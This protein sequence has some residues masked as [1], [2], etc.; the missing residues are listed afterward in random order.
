[1]YIRKVVLYPIRHTAQNFP[2]RR[3]WILPEWFMFFSGGGD[4]GVVFLLQ[5]ILLYIIGF[6]FVCLRCDIS[7]TIHNYTKDL[8]VLPQGAGHRGR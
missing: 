5:S 8:S 7:M 3:E 1:M 6:F 4:V 2:K